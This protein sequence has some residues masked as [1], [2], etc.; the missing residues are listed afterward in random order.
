[1]ATLLTDKELKLLIGTVIV[2]GV[3]SSV[4]PNS[5]ILRLGSKGEFL[6]SN[7]EFELGKQKYTIH[8]KQ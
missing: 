8:D 3:T 7:K 1:M 5:Y 4:R 6:S 2:G